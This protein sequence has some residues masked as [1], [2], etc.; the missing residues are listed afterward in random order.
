MEEGKP[1]PTAI[2]GAMMRAAHLLLDDDPKIL[3]DDLAIQLSGLKDN[4]ALQAVVDA[5]ISKISHHAD[6]EFAHRFVRYLRAEVS[7][8][9]RYAEDELAKAIQGGVT[10]Y[11]ILG[12]GLDSFVYRNRNVGKI[13]QVFEIDHPAT[14]RWKQDILNTLEMETP[15]NLTFIP[16]DFERKTLRESLHENGYRFDI[17]CFFSWLAV[18]PY[19]TEDAIFNTLKDIESLAAGTEVVFEYMVPDSL[20]N[21][22]DQR[23]ALVAKAVTSQGGEQALSFFD[24]VELKARVQSMGFTVI[25]DFGPEDANERYFAGRKDG[26]RA[27]PSFHLM[28]ARVSSNA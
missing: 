9:S 12:A 3:Q 20:L 11:V 13:L 4:A 17:P 15:S 6:T 19:L 5:M 7:Q 18:T 10:Q 23:T 21:E 2:S 8:R 26:L 22:E 28:K 25:E 24:P 27:F 14:Q 16:L 1:S